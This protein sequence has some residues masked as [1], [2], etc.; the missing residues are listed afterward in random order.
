MDKADRTRYK[1]LAN[2]AIIA[3]FGYNNRESRLATSLEACLDEL[4]TIATDCEHCKTC[5]YHGDFEDDSIDVDVSELLRIHG[6]LKKSVAELK[7][8]HGKFG[9]AIAE[10]DIDNLV[11]E[12]ASQIEETQGRVDE[13]EAEVL[14]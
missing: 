7:D 5:T 2:D 8:L 6:E 4:E 1:T 3:T 12:L 11:E 14:S 9:N 13:L 10:S